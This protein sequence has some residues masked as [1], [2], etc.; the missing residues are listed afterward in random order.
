[1]TGF[2]GLQH[3][4]EM[5]AKDDFAENPAC[6]SAGCGDLDEQDVSTGEPP[7]HTD[8]RDTGRRWNPITLTSRVFLFQMTATATWTKRTPPVLLPTTTWRV[9]RRVSA[10]FTAEA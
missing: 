3:A 8:A 7:G 6:H 2:S 5:E 10:T 1:M 9:T 4:S